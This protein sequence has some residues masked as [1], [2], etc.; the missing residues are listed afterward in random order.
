MK[1]MRHVLL[2]TGLG[3]V[4]IATGLVQ[5]APCQADDPW[6]EVVAN[7]FKGQGQLVE[8]ITEDYYTPLYWED[9]SEDD[10]ID[11]TLPYG[12]IWFFCGHGDVTY[13]GLNYLIAEPGEIYGAEIP[14]LHN[15]H[16]FDQMRFAFASACYSGYFSYE[17]QDLYEGFLNNGAEAY[18]GWTGSIDSGPASQYVGSF[19]AYC[20]LVD[21]PQN[22][23][24]ARFNAVE[25][26]EGIDEGDIEL[27]GNTNVSLIP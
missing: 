4:L 8:T 24:Q 14:G 11:Y 26:I 9:A 20:F 13:W 10:I 3:M 25:D 22:V 18:M 23:G 1:H 17:W 27:R 7:D 6:S 21:P 16:E 5:A 15:Q 12:D 19:Y 2:A